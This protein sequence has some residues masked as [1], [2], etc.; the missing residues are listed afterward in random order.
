MRR[1]IQLPIHHT[2][3]CNVLFGEV[4]LLL[5]IVNMASDMFDCYSDGQ[6][7]ENCHGLRPHVVIRAYLG[8]CLHVVGYAGQ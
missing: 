4:D 1:G 6:T 5:G 2:V 8:C 7:A 3:R